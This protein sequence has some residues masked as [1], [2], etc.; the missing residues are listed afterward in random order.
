VWMGPVTLLNQ[1]YTPDGTLTDRN[2]LITYS[3]NFLNTAV[4]DLSYNYIF[5]RLT[6]DFNPVGADNN[7]FLQGERY[8]WHTGSVIFKS[9]TRKI[10]N[11][12]FQTTYG[13]FYNGTNFNINGQLK[14]RYQP[15][16]NISL[17]VDYNDV[18]LAE[19]YGQ[20]KLFLIGPRIDL[21]FT[22]RLFLT[23]YYQY[24]N[25]LDN[26]NLNVRFQ[27]RYQPV[28]DIFLVYTENYFPHDFKSKNRALVF[29][30][31]YWLNL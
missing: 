23:T 2:Y 30:L 29:K 5:Q 1:T 31:T 13:G 3:F 18:N 27:W 21:T 15:Y 24:N 11:V 6:N 26:M 16:G 10:F 19:N 17:L 8:S 7:R 4:L 28:S 22:D 20:E 12:I 9:N 14:A 25:L